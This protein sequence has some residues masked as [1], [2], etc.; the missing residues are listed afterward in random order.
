MNIVTFLGALGSDAELKEVGDNKLLDFSVG[1]N[2]GYG[3][4]KHCIWHKCS[5][6]GKRAEGLKAH[7]LKGVKVVV[8]GEHDLVPNKDGTKMY[9]NVNVNTVNIV[10]YAKKIDDSKDEPVATD[11]RPETVDEEGLPF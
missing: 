6:W 7:M 5:V 2:V 10:E 8:T 3:D 4:K 11:T 1:V 9:S